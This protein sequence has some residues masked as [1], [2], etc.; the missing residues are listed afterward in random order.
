MS[1]PRRG[2]TLRRIR[3]GVAEARGPHERKIG[4][5]LV[6]GLGASVGPARVVQ[7]LRQAM[8]RDERLE[9]ITI[10]TRIALERARIPTRADPPPFVD[11]P[12]LNP[13]A[14]WSTLM[15]L[16]KRRVAV[17]NVFELA[18]Y[19][20]VWIV[21]ARLIGAQLVYTAHGSVRD[22]IAMGSKTSPGSSLAERILLTQ[23]DGFVVVSGLL[24][25]RLLHH[26]TRLGPPMAIIHNGVAGRFLEP[27][28]PSSFFRTHRPARQV[29]LFAGALSRMKGIDLLLKACKGMDVTLV[30][31]G[32]R[33][34]FFDG[35][36]EEWSE[37]I[38]GGRL[39]LAG[40]LETDLLCSAYAAAR[41]FVMPSR[42]DSCPLA[43]LEA[44]AAGC[45]VIISDAVG[46]AEQIT[47][48]VDGFVVPAGSSEA[49]RERLMILLRDDGMREV[50][51]RNARATAASLVW[52]N[53]EREYFEAYSRLIGPT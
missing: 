42:Q 21:L 14:W 24:Y 17:I 28:D 22:E 39:L 48:G 2:A 25:S 18:L 46:T 7:G 45:P 53:V 1:N 34:P 49:L 16:R 51:G 52:E 32:W 10:S 20:L 11:L 4:V 27:A 15:T 29:V 35:L 44:M 13:L 5:A 47:D 9:T 38:N 37:M 41:V 6:G 12:V 23:A 43:V 50:V 36:Q 33:T 40:R 26:Y 31:A 19:S 30:L 8:A 3:G